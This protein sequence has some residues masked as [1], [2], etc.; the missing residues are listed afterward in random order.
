MDATWQEI[1]VLQQRIQKEAAQGGLCLYPSDL[2]IGNPNVHGADIYT[3][4][5]GRPTE[6]DT[7]SK[8]CLYKAHPRLYLKEA[9]VREMELNVPSW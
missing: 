7:F 8:E 6:A 2:T 9:D 1:A 5:I 3:V 4:M